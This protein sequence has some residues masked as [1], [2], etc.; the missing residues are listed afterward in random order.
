MSLRVTGVRNDGYHLID[1]VMTTL[2]LHDELQITE[3]NSGLEFNGPYASGISA[4]ANNLVAR[5]LA[6]VGRCRRNFPLGS[7]NFG[8][9]CCCQCRNRS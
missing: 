3:G 8:G 5:A 4:D 9:R 2:D 7:T 6:F 1:A